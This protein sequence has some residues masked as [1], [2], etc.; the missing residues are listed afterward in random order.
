MALGM[1]VALGTFTFF[2]RADIES[3]PINTLGEIRPAFEGRIFVLIAQLGRCS[4]LSHINQL[5]Y[6]A[7][8]IQALFGISVVAGAGQE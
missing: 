3:R 4:I 7:L 1:G 5:H 8:C 6:E 2:N